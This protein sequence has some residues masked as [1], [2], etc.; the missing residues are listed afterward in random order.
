VNNPDGTLKWKAIWS[1][2][3]T[4]DT[5]GHETERVSYNDSGEVTN[6]TVW[7]YETNG[8]LNKVITYGAAAE[9]T[10]YDT[11]EYDE[12]GHK[13]RTDYFNSN[14]STRGN[15]LFVYDSR[16]YPSEIRI[17]SKTRREVFGGQARIIETEI[18]Y[19]TI[20]YRQPR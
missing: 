13:I 8:N 19:R 16:G 3:S 11:F 12:N 1:G 15:D 2:R 4:Y 14:G 18:T 5:H 17:K 7:I 6:R 9:I 20:T 10:F